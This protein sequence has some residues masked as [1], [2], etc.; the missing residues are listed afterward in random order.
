MSDGGGSESQD[1]MFSDKDELSQS[2][3]H[4]SKFSST[5]SLDPSKV[6]ADQDREAVNNALAALN[7]SP[8]T[9]KKW[10]EKEYPIKKVNQ[11]ADVVKSKLNIDEPDSNELTE[12][13]EQMKGAFVNANKHGNKLGLSCAK[14]SRSWG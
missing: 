5:G 14:L 1:T 12:I 4:A 13:L 6:R 11:I 2:S 10:K 9:V 8:V 3:S 7:V